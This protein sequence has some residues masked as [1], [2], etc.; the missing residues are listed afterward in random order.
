MGIPA[1]V[2]AEEDDGLQSVAVQPLQPFLQFAQDFL[3]VFGHCNSFP[4]KLYVN[5]SRNGFF[6]SIG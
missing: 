5:S 4:G 1:R 3:E 2:G 6:C